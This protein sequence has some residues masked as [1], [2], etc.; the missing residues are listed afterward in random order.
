MKVACSHGLRCFL[1]LTALSQT[2]VQFG[3]N[4]MKFEIPKLTVRGV[5]TGVLFSYFQ[6]E[7]NVAIL[8]QLA[9]GTV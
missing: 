3:N 1:Q 9:K 8:G 4:W 7:K 6:T 5:L 2:A